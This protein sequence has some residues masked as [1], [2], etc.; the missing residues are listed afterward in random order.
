M[1]SA[2][3]P[4]FKAL[5]PMR[6]LLTHPHPLVLPNPY[7]SLYSRTTQAPTGVTLPGHR[8]CA[9]LGDS[10]V[11]SWFSAHPSSPLPVNFLSCPSATP[12]GHLGCHHHPYVPPWRCQAPATHSLTTGPPQP[13][14]PPRKPRS[15]SSSAGLGGPAPGLMAPALGHV[16]VL[17][18]S[19][20][21]QTGNPLRA[22]TMP[23][24]SLGF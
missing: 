8:A 1:T 20:S 12:P 16:R 24:L 10:R 3:T 9:L 23:S 19:A 5:A 17:L 13:K 2:F 6:V 22:E 18:P 4:L 11:R 7:P 21:H 15:V 14:P